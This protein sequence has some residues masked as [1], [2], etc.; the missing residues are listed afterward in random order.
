M[1]EIVSDDEDA[2]IVIRGS[3]GLRMIDTLTGSTAKRLPSGEYVVDLKGD[4]N[5]FEL[6]KDRFV[7]KRGDKVIVKVTT[8]KNQD[9]PSTVGS[10]TTVR[11]V[12]SYPVFGGAPSP[13][14]RSVSHPM[15]SDLAV[16]DLIKGTS[17]RLTKNRESGEFAYIQ[18]WSPNGKEIVTSWWLPDEHCLRTQPRLDWHQAPCHR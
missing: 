1:L 14:G 6:D 5:A 11:R 4:D 18:V 16:R 10:G 15:G 17:R 3:D 12:W 8:K 13:D 7:L 9:L 2:E